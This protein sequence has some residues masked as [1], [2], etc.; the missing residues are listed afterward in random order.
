MPGIQ[1]GGIRGNQVYI[2][3]AKQSGWGAPLAPASYWRWLTGSRANPLTRIQTWREGDTSAYESFAAKR[4]QWWVVRVV[5]YL[6]PITAGAAIQALLG[7]GSDAFTAPTVS[8]TL[9]APIT[10][11]ATTFQTTT[12]IGIAGTRWCAFTPGYTSASNE[13]LNVDLA[14]RTGGGPYTYALAA[15]QRFLM[16]HASG[17]AVASASTHTFNRQYAY[18]PYT[19]E[20]GYG[21]GGITPNAAFRIQDCICYDLEFEAVAGRPVRLTHLWYGISGKTQTTLATPA[22]EGAGLLGTAGRPLVMAD[23]GNTWKLKNATT[24]N[25]ATIARLKLKLHNTTRPD[26][27]RDELLAPA[28]FVPGHLEITGSME[29]HFASFQEYSQAYYGSASP[30]AG[31][32]DSYSIGYESLNVTFAADGVNGLTLALPNIAYAAATLAPQTSGDVLRQPL[33]FRALP[34]SPA[35]PSPVTLTLTNTYNTPY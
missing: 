1:P 14:S 16:R 34:A 2:G 3:W 31:S 10:P 26:A 28:Y 4:G 12:T 32:T 29:V 25:A 27:I 21:A 5:E 15:G 20:T 35:S 19:I 13:A 23:A 6:R 7:S 17:D 9:A 24:G 33:V 22:F 8:A 11:G 30:P 18:D